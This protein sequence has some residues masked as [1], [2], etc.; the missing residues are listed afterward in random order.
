MCPALGN[1]WHTPT[2]HSFAHRTSLIH[3]GTSHSAMRLN[4]FWTSPQ[5]RTTSVCV[6]QAARQLSLRRCFGSRVSTRSCRRRSIPRRVPRTSSFGPCRSQGPLDAGTKDRGAGVEFRSA[7]QAP[8]AGRTRR[9]M[10]G[11][12]HDSAD[13]GLLEPP[14]ATLMS[15]HRIATEL[16]ES[17]DHNRTLQPIVGR[18]PGF[19]EKAAYQVMQSVSTALSQ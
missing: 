11:G 16:L 2:L 5:T 18:E 8:A 7:D 6:K 3:C 19:D 12:T 1:R 14:K 15:I 9:S 10:G 17:L 13:H 4:P